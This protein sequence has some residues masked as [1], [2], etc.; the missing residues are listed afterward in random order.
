MITCSIFDHVKYSAQEFRSRDKDFVGNGVLKPVTDFGLTF[1]TT[2]NM[3]ASPAAGTA[4]VDGYRI[5]YDASPAQTLT[6]ATAD[7]TNPRID[8]VEIGYT[9]SGVTGAGV[10][11]IVKGTAAGTPIQPQPDT[12]FI[13]IFA[14]HIAAG[15]TSIIAGN[16][17]D[18]R[19]AVILSGAATT[20]LSSATPTLETI[21]SSGN[22]GTSSAASRADHQH[23][24][25]AASDILTAIETVDG[26]GSGLDAD[27]LDGHDS[28]YFAPLASSALTGTPT[29]PTPTTGDNSTK[30]STTAFVAAAIAALV[31]SSPSALDTLKELADALGDDPNFATTMTNALAAKAPLASPVFTGT[32]TFPAT[33]QASSSAPGLVEVAAVPASGAPIVSS[34]V[35]SAKETQITGTTAQTVATY[36]PAASGNFEARASFRVV[37][38]T[39]NVTI[40]ITYTSAGGVQT[41]Y[42]LN[43]QA[44]AVGEYSIVPFAFNAVAGSAITIK[45][46]ASVANQVYASCGIT[47]V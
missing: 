9:G 8:L 32:V 37:T 39:T 14:I 47:G 41:Y 27:L 38:G 3:T 45:V 1:P 26:A 4:W 36:T 43:V 17:T 42:A 11:Q 21:G 35:A 33:N 15:A 34:Q 12:G 44:C 7:P 18:L 24:M 20:P 40:V 46:T 31:N 2:P 10:I 30:I 16:V 19:A 5:G 13:G 22:P 28:T 23:G 6:F 29:A 25:P